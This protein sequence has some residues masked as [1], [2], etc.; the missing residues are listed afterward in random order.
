MA[1]KKKSPTPLKRK[2]AKA[3]PVKAPPVVPPIQPYS[4]KV[5]AGRFATESLGVEGNLALAEEEE[6][7]IFPAI[8]HVKKRA[9]LA[10]YMTCCSLRGATKASGVDWKNHYFWRERDE[11]YAKAFDRAHTIGKHA[12]EDEATRRA[13]GWNDHTFDAEGNVTE[14]YKASDLLLIFRLKAELGDKYRER[15]SIEHD[16]SPAMATLVQLWQELRDHPERAHGPL[17]GPGEAM[18][19][20]DEHADWMDAEVVEAEPGAQ[21]SADELA[22]DWELER[23]TAEVEQQEGEV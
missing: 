14:K 3:A 15:S 13:M 12:L 7:D 6:S 16:V 21:A 10:A 1:P 8:Q 22:P 11:E 5:D 23:E 4:E 19:M 17:P 2:R 9:F 20:L 18:P